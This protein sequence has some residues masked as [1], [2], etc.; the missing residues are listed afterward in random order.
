MKAYPK[1]SRMGHS[2]TEGILTHPVTIV[3]KMD[4]A[5]FRF[6]VGDNVDGA[7]DDELIFGSRNVVYKNREDIDKNFLHAVDYVEARVEPEDFRNAQRGDDELVLFGE[8]NH[9]HT[10]SYGEPEDQPD[11][12]NT[13][14]DVPNVTIFDA[15]SAEEGWLA[16][17][18]INAISKRLKIP[19][20]PLVYRQR[21]Y[22]SPDELPDNITSEYRDGPAEG[23]IIRNEVLGQRAKL[24]SEEFLDKHAG[25]GP[26]ASSDHVSDDTSELVAEVL[27]KEPWVEKQIHKYRNEGRDINMSIMESLWRSVFDDIIDEEYET[28][29]LG[30]WDINTKDFRSEIASHTAER[31][32]QYMNRP[33]DSALNQDPT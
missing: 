27:A 3:E 8:A 12:A 5:N 24:R 32:R 30:N 20:V 16:W 1:I 14:K 25:G 9:A 26:S 31:L 10:L 33:D 6:T 17:D 11:G 21:S 29:L 18:S 15:W 2:D 13:W 23:I 28:I 22:D 19:T 4:G 7:P